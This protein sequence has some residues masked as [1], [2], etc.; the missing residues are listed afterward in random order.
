MAE[1]F[2]YINQLIENNDFESIFD[3]NGRFI[4]SEN[5]QIIFNYIETNIIKHN[6]TSLSIL[7]YISL[8]KKI[9]V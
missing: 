1:T 3:K 7:Y 9:K 4:F 6:L 2:D 5:Y 8:L